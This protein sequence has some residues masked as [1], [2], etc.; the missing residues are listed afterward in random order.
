MV[1]LKGFRGQGTQHKLG[2][3]GRLPGGGGASAGH[4]RAGRALVI[5][6]FRAQMGRE[7]EVQEVSSGGAA[8]GEVGGEGRG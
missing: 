5:E 2:G 1:T 7:Q 8:E 4:Q 6:E 3:Q